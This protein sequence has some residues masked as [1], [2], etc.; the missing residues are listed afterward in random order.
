MSEFWLTGESQSPV[1]MVSAEGGVDIEE[2]AANRPDAIHAVRVDPRYGLQSY[3]A[4]GLA[5]RLYQGDTPAIRTG[6]NVIFRLYNAFVNNGASLAEINP[7]VQNRA[8][9]VLAIDAK[10]VIGRQRALSPSRAR[11]PPRRERRNGG[12]P[13][14]PARRL[15]FR[16]AGGKRWLLCQ[17]AQGWRWRPWTW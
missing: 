9:Q 8:G 7:L 12:R 2:V 11:S 4:F 5:A 15:E 3:Q 16:Q 14:G 17:T 13:S 6:A 10:V 1:V